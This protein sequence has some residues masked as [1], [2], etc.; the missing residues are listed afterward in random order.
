M[1]FRRDSVRF[2]IPQ[3]GRMRWLL[4]FFCA[5]AGI[6]P[7]PGASDFWSDKKPADWS[8]SQIEEFLTRSPWVRYF[9]GLRTWSCVLM[10]GRPQSYPA[11]SLS[12]RLESAD[13]VRDALRRIESKEYNALAPSTDT[14]S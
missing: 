5:M 13:I 1:T 9:A 12:I 4:L 14:N 8:N 6:G 11:G 3:P 7:L 2:R 10:N